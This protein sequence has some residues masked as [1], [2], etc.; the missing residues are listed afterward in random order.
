MAAPADSTA[1]SHSVSRP[2]ERLEM[3]DEPMRTNRSSTMRTF[4]CTL[5]HAPS[6]SG[7]TGQYARKCPY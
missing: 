3:L 4:A 2:I 7:T 6:R 5:R 1:T